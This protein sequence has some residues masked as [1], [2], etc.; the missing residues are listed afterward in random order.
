[1]M[2]FTPPPSPPPPPPAK[3]DER[4]RRLAASGR[5]QTMLTGGQGLVEDAPVLKKT[6]GA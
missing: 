5:T 3:E 6:L 2:C 1:M 4:K